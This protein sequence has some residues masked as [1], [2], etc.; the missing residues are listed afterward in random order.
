LP[1]SHRFTVR[2]GFYLTLDLPSATGPATMDAC[3]SA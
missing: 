2:E 1:R 3:R